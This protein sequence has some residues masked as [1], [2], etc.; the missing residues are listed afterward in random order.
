M[1]GTIA[2][3]SKSSSQVKTLIEEYIYEK[4]NEATS[5][6]RYEHTKSNHQQLA[7][8]TVLLSADM[9]QKQGTPC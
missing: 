7:L 6:P 2:P 1:S 9:Y 4:K 5:Q 8:L 3:S